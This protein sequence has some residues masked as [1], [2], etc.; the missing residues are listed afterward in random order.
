MGLLA[1]SRMIQRAVH[2][3]SSSSALNG[4]HTHFVEVGHGDG[5]AAM[6]LDSRRG[7][8]HELVTVHASVRVVVGERRATL[9]LVVG[10]AERVGLLAVD[11]LVTDSQDVGG[12]T[13]GHAE[14]GTDDEQDQRRPSNVPSDSEEEAWCELHRLFLQLTRKLDPDLASVARNSAALG[15]AKR[16]RSILR[17]TGISFWLGEGSQN[18]T[19]EAPDN[20]CDEMGVHHAECIV[21]IAQRRQTAEE[22]H[23]DPGDTSAENTEEDS[24]PT[25]DNASTRGDGDEPCRERVL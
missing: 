16:F 24:R 20:A 21:D 11:R 1:V 4:A 25:S 17:G 5:V 10:H 7:G 14:H 13:E 9:G 18:A 19:K 8:L 23:G 2:P 3:G 6:V 22:V 15:E 12:R